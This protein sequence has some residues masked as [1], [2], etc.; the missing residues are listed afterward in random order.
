MR[1]HQ[2]H[3][4]K[5]GEIPPGVGGL[6]LHSHNSI[7]W[8]GWWPSQL[9]W[10][11]GIAKAGTLILKLGRSWKPGTSWSPYTWVKIVHFNHLSDLESIC[12][13]LATK[14]CPSLCH[15]MDYSPL[16][17]SVHGVFQARIWEWVDIFFSRFAWLRDQTCVSCIGRWIL[18][19]WGT[20]EAPQNVQHNSYFHAVFTLHHPTLEWSEIT[21]N[22]KQKSWARE[23][24]SPLRE[25][26]NGNLTLGSQFWVW[27]RT[28]HSNFLIELE[29]SKLILVIWSDIKLCI[30]H[31]WSEKSWKWILIE[32]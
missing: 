14:L 11:E 7:L 18:Y 32:G 31:R 17:S 4:G 28:G 1:A 19:C 21:S 27:H 5:T 6:P 8:V 23:S 13:C 9:M 30:T 10:T 25:K 24:K 29:K 16:G 2:V 26:C 3:Q 22:K 12:C 15:P 20:W